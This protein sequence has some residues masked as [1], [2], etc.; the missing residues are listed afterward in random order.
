VET[1]PSGTVRLPNSHES[2]ST[3]PDF[4]RPTSPETP[5]DPGRASRGRMPRVIVD[6]RVP[7]ARLGEAFEGG[8]LADFPREVEMPVG[9]PRRLEVPYPRTALEAH[10]EG[11]VLAWAIVDPKG[12]VEQTTIVAGPGDFNE[13]VK[14]T[15]AKTR[16]IPAR[17]GGKTIR[18]YIV[19]KFEFRIED[20]GDATARSASA[21]R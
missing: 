17:D 11:T 18:Y 10:R 12:V 2:A 14:A 7:R 8:P 13:A 3:S 1:A 21:P 19:L 4:N 5:G 16:L 6:D 20:R 9:L 15:L